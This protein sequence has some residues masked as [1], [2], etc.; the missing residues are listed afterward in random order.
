[1][2]RLFHEIYEERKKFKEL[3]KNNPNDMDLGR[4]VRGMML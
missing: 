3:V 4:Q 2:M 1:M